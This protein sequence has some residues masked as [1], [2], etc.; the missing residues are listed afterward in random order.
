MMSIDL[1]RYPIDDLASEV[2]R[3]LVD[4][5]REELR[6]KGVCRLEGFITPEATARMAAEA[7]RLVPLNYHSVVEGNA[8]LEPEDTSLP[9]GHPKRLLDKTALGVLAYD[10][11]P[12]A[13]ELRRLYEW[14][15]F[16]AYLA[17]AL[18]HERLFRYADPMGAL[19]IAVMKDGDYLRWHF[20]QTDFVVSIALQSSLEG[21]EFEYAPRIRAKGSENYDD[22]RRVLR[23]TSDKVER[24]PMDPG[25]LILFEG[26]YSLHRVTPIAGSRTRLVALLG[27]DAKPGVRSSEHLQYM[28]YGRTVP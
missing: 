5:S 10:Q 28:R 1:K 12:E 23:G 7:E 8:Y 9:E 21:G 27:Y 20:D 2:G 14:D 24:L 22:V 17:A 6:G 19:N 18:G 26:R 25:T 15:P 13:T 4:R 11:I 3:R 16:M